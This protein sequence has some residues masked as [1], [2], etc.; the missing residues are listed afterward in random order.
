MFIDDRL[1][2]SFF[3]A[4]L[5]PGY[6]TTTIERST[7]EASSVATKSSLGL[8]AAEIIP[9]LELS[10]GSEVAATKSSKRGESRTLVPIQNAPRELVQLAL[11][12]L[13]RLATPE[14][15]RIWAELS[16]PADHNWQPP[17]RVRIESRPRM[18]AFLDFP[19][20]TRFVPMAVETDEGVVAVYEQLVKVLTPD[21]GPECPEYPDDPATPD[22]AQLSDDYWRWFVAN[23]N[24]TKALVALEEALKDTGR[25]RWVNYR[26]PVQ[27]GLTLHLNVV[28]HG[29]YDTGIFAYNLIKRGWRQGLRVV[30]TIRAEPGLNVLAIYDK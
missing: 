22:F 2:S 24:A 19:S 20:G 29:D 4:V 21:G 30:G 7:E 6:R 10:V 16:S 12:Y 14:D 26:V 28:G 11:H 27:D 5:R 17:P 9:G 1:V 15:N 8:K 3:D 25:P 18:L 23:W 13:T